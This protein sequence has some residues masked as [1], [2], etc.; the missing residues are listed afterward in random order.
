VSFL[1]REKKGMSEAVSI[2][3]WLAGI[4]AVLA[5]WALFE[6]VLMPL[7]RWAVMH[8]ANQVIDDVGKRLRIGIRP[9]QRTRRQALIHRLLTDPKVQQAA[10]QFA[11]KHKISLQ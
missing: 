6:H 7:L 8:P 5:A 2:P 10:E 1:A 11:A 4:G 3:F 9:F